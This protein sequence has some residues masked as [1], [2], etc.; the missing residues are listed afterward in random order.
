MMLIDRIIDDRSM[1][2]NKKILQN[3]LLP[4]CSSKVIFDIS[5]LELFGKW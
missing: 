4:D 1:A 5:F 3:L 2:A